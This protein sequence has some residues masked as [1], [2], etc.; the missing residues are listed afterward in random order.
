VSFLSFNAHPGISV[1]DIRQQRG[2]QVNLR[3]FIVVAFGM[4][5]YSIFVSLI[6]MQPVPREWPICQNYNF[7]SQN[8]FVR[9]N[10]FGTAQSKCEICPENM[11]KT[12]PFQ[13]GNFNWRMSGRKTTIFWY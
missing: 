5:I 7:P 11:T 12:F 13:N 9:L 3:V 4:E 1:R 6:I 2:S 8:K 10:F